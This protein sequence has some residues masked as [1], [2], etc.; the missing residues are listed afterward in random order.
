M[1]NTFKDKIA[2]LWYAIVIMGVYFGFEYIY[3]LSQPATE[4]IN[5]PFA[6]AQKLTGK[7]VKVAVID[8]G[9]DPEHYMLN[10]NFS[11]Y[12][13]NVDHKNWD[14]SETPYFENGEVSFVNHGTHV[15]G[16]IAGAAKSIGVAPGASII[17]IKMGLWGRDQAFVKALEI[18]TKSEAHI[19]NISM[20]ISH[21]VNHIG[22]NVAQS[23]ID[24]ADSGKI[25]VIAAGNDGISM[26]DSGYSRDLIEL[27]HDPRMNGRMII[28]GATSYKY[29]SEKRAKF[30][31]YL[32]R[33]SILF[34][35]YFVMA[36]G[37]E[38]ISAVFGNKTDK[39]SGTSMAAPMVSGSLALLKERF[40]SLKP[41]EL[42]ALLLKSARKHQWN[43][44]GS[45]NLNEFGNGV[46]D[47]K[48]AI[49][50]GEELGY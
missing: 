28:V 17:P 12:R 30:S 8:E 11:R 6:H 1:R 7:N 5:A 42:V 23:L 35:S 26:L 50:M 47:I 18:A 32:N 39:M 36:P 46:I 21:S 24:L 10:S 41:E 14:V 33:R 49:A 38:V 4:I 27:A 44:S 37:D 3:P 20:Q 19:V 43:S 29:L 2:L 40:P 13:F 16:I 9:F 45:L 31:N 15:S 25:V 34:P 48:S 22:D